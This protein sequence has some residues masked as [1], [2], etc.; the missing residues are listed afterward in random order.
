M[1][2]AIVFVKTAEGTNVFST[3]LD[4]IGFKH[5]PY[6][7][8]VFD[9]DKD[10]RYMFAIDQ[11]MTSTGICLATENLSFVFV[12]TVA[13]ATND[14]VLRDKY[15]EDV[16]EFC[17]GML[18][19]VSLRFRTLEDVPPSKYSRVNILLPTLKGYIDRGLETIPA[20]RALGRDYKFCILPGTW[21]STIYDKSDKRD[22]AFNNKREIARDLVK[23]YP[24]IQPYF[25]ELVKQTGHDYD[26]MDAFG[27]TLH[28]RLKR[29]TPEWNLVNSAGK[30]QLGRFN[31]LFR[32]FDDSEEDDIKEKL[33]IPLAPWIACDL[34]ESRVWNDNASIFANLVMAA[35]SNKVVVMECTNNKQILAAL[36]EFDL[37]FDRASKLFVVVGKNTAKLNLLS[38][39]RVQGLVEQ[40]FC[41]KTYYRE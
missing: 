22:G 15:L 16:I 2:Y 20:V 28:T 27:M 39:S 30:Y 25:E 31:V 29:F 13:I 34:L 3:G 23:K 14:Q 40:G 17:R 26:G 38:E 24:A 35:N 8:F 18:E 32:Y 19:G 36:I 10:K 1:A 9:I 41:V 6:Y 11:S 7:N 37:T 12:A 21:K 5:D 33:I 4:R